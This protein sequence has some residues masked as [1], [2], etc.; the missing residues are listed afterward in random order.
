LTNIPLIYHVSY[1]SLGLVASFWGLSPPKAPPWRRDLV[2]AQRS[3]CNSNQPMR[4]KAHRCTGCCPHGTSQ[5]VL[6]EIEET[7]LEVVRDR[8]AIISGCH[9]ET[10]YSH[11]RHHLAGEKSA[12][13]RRLFRIACCCQAVVS[14]HSSLRRGEETSPGMPRNTSRCHDATWRQAHRTGRQVTVR[15]LEQPG[16]VQEP[17][18]AWC[19]Q[20]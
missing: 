14:R 9:R 20:K 4:H 18:N 3:D 17:S 7:I 2:V 11:A 6:V 16:K 8:T 15:T 13:A 5:I 1:F 10:N 12:N 19:A